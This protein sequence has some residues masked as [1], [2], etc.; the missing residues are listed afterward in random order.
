M[1]AL[2]HGLR[3]WGAVERYSAALARALGD[4]AVLVFPDDP[5][6]QPFEE[7]GVRTEPYPARLLGSAPGGTRRLAAMLR[8]LRPQIVHATE[9]FPPALVA[10]RLAGVRRLLVTHHTPELPRRDNPAGRLWR[11]LGWAMR[12]LV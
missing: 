5:A 12:P 9:V 8:R 11:R 1:I 3:A 4:E 2:V 7:L 10:A 6:L